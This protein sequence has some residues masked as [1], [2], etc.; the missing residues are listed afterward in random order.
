M[1]L[2]ASQKKANWR[3]WKV[4]DGANTVNM[5]FSWA[6]LICAPKR[7]RRFHELKLV[8][9]VPLMGALFFKNSFSVACLAV[10]TRSEAICGHLRKS[11]LNW[12]A[13]CIKT[14]TAQR[15]RLMLRPTSCIRPVSLMALLSARHFRY[16]TAMKTSLSAIWPSSGCMS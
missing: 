3:K 8:Y 15:L 2:L 12:K 16:S 1:G 6:L 11:P 10:F 9:H 13:R 4:L 7:W 5:Y 14:L